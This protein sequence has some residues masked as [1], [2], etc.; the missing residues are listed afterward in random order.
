MN[1]LL[2][3]I[4]SHCEENRDFLWWSIVELILANSTLKFVDNDLIIRAKAIV[5]YLKLQIV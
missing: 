4:V 2:F 1:Q 3:C 5:V